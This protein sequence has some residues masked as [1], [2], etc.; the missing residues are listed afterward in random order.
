MFYSLEGILLSLGFVCLGDFIRG[1]G[2]CSR[3]RG[4]VLPRDEIY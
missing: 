1:V 4:K 2:K 3:S